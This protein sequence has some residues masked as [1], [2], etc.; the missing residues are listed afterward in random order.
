[1]KRLCSGLAVLLTLLHAAPAASQQ[2]LALDGYC[3]FDGSPV[4]EDVYGFASDQEAQDALQRLMQHTGLEP[5]F[6]LRAGNVPN[7]M[8]AIQGAQRLIV[9]N[10]QFMLRVRDQTR[11]EWA[12]ISILAHEIGHHLQGH[13]LQPG[14]SRPPI[15]LEADKYSGYV[16]QRMGATLEQA[17]AA[18]NTV[19]SEQGSATHPG[20]QARLAAITNGWIQAR[21]LN[22]NQP[23]TGAPSPNPTQQ[24]PPQPSTSSPA[25]SY[26]ARAVFPADP[27][28]YYVTASG[29]IVAIDPQT[30]QTVIVGRRIPAT[31]PGFAWM[32]HTPY[33]TYGVTADG[34]IIN[35]DQFGNTFQIGYITQ[36]DR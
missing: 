6:V 22:R 24:N 33:I 11:T 27:I 16:L 14:G 36:P 32:Y 8:A 2:L 31:A 10:Q 3:V 30:Q 5:N 4:T 20:R 29:E 13:T 18:M 15:E 35:R 19:A 34:R 25:T 21:D 12:A 7:A 28:A 17:Q 26:V 23:S 9:Y 1:M